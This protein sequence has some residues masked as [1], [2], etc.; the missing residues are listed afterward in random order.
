MDHAIPLRRKVIVAISCIALVVG[1]IALALR[2]DLLATPKPPAKATRQTVEF[3]DGGK[4]EILGVSLGE[5][6]IEDSAAKSFLPTMFIKN[7]GSSLYTSGGNER[8]LSVV[9]FMENGRAVRFRAFT[10]ASSGMLLEIR[11]EKA[12][13][14]PV[15][16]PSYLTAR[17][18]VQ[19]DVRLGGKHGISKFRPFDDSVEKMSEAMKKAGLKLLVQQRDPHAGWIDLTGPFLFNEAWPDRYMMVL[20]AWQRNLPILGFRAILA[21]G[22]VAEF[23][24]PNPDLRK[25]PAA[26]AGVVSAALPLVHRGSDFTLTLRQVERFSAPGD[27]PFAAV[28][29]DLK[30]DGAPVPG[31]KY[32]PVSFWESYMCA[33]DEWGNKLNFRSD[34]IGKKRRFGAFLPMN[35]RRMAFNVQVARN[36]N[37]PRSV[38]AGFTVLEGVVSPDGLT[39]DFKPGVDAALFGVHTMPTC[40]VTSPSPGW[41]GEAQKDWKELQYDI[42]GN[43]DRKAM[44]TIQSRIG[45][46]D[47]WTFPLFA[48]ESSVSGGLSGPG[49]GG[50]GGGE[51]NGGFNFSR[52]FCCTFPPELLGPGAKIR[53]GI[54]G[55]L[56]K[57]D[58]RFQVELPELVQPR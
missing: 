1:L 32:G 57:D 27:H 33:E 9:R 5:R 31:M 41:Y 52:S 43:S 50:S 11:L 28:E 2:L 35:S 48:G 58:V 24:L 42:K 49:M 8:G 16:L 4:L 55:P 13:G 37:Y 12:N 23:S 14:I 7:L 34:M 30:Y 3:R 17:D 25:A 44:Q 10:E 39:V 45:E 18:C 15:Q 51:S 19:E 36:E 47:K 6:V 22:Q 26:I 54:H 29:M 40:R 21:D 56:K 38:H 20:T 53:V 46:G